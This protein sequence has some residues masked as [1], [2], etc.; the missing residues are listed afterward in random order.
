M[1]S[2]AAYV[3]ITGMKAKKCQ[4]DTLSPSL[5]QKRLYGLSGPKRWRE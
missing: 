1:Y 5:P 2:R 3:T 4:K